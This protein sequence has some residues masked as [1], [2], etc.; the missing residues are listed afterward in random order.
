[1][2]PIPNQNIIFKRLGDGAVIFNCAD[3]VY[4]GLN[5]EG[6]RIWELLP[7]ASR[8]VDDLVACLAAENPGMSAETIRADVEDLLQSLATFGLVR[9][10]DSKA[11]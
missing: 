7:P 1:M 2:L 4:F 5:A 8:S 6:A 10:A 9:P 11:A 3:E